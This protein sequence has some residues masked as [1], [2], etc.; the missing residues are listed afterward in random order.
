MPVA[1]QAPSYARLTFVLQRGYKLTKYEAVE[2]IHVHHRTA[3]RRLQQ[4]YDEGHLRIVAWKRAENQ[5][6]AQYAWGKGKDAVKPAPIPHNEVQRKSR[7]N[8][9]TRDKQL[10]KRRVI[11][12][13]KKADTV[14]ANQIFNL[15]VKRA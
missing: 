7:N 8:P 15:L 2:W 13:I 4:L 12:V 5:W 11:R 1:K 9:E 10:S 6:I 3:Q 14:A